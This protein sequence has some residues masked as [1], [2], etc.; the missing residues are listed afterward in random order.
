[1][2]G[3]VSKVEEKLRRKADRT[4]KVTAEYNL[5][6]DDIKTLCEEFENLKIHK[7]IKEIERSKGNLEQT[8]IF[9]QEKERRVV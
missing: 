7:V 8:R 9:L 5:K 6:A 1:M 2:E 3:D 4:E